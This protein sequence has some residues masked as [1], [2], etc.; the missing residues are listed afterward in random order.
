MKIE[1]LKFVLSEIEAG[2][3]DS[4]LGDEYEL[5]GDN[6]ASFIVSLSDVCGK[7]VDQ[8]ALLEKERDESLERLEVQSSNV[9]DAQ[10]MLAQ[11]DLCNAELVADR[12]AILSRVDK[13]ECIFT[14]DQIKVLLTAVEEYEDSDLSSIREDALCSEIEDVLNEMLKTQSEVSK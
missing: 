4:V 9:R 5:V 10:T 12:D 8:I 3:A 14:V 1:K 6:N 13:D 7:A 11:S 2:G